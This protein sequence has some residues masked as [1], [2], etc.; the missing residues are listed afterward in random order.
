MQKEIIYTNKYE[1]PIGIITLACGKEGLKGLWFEGQKYFGSNILKGEMQ[2][3]KR[4]EE[5]ACEYCEVSLLPVFAETVKWLDIYFGGKNP[6]FTPRLNLVGTE[7]QKEVWEMLLQIPYGQTTTYK[8]IAEK[9][10]QNRGLTSMSA[11]AVG[12]AVG[13]N[14]ISVIVPCHR[15]I[16]SNG[17]LTGYAAGVEK[18]RWLLQTEAKIK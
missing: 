1:S 14:P 3:V 4:Q 15:V 13:H 7:F 9:I 16:G 6:G 2:L 17:S 5:T 11:Q 10:A 12:S 18:K 8:E